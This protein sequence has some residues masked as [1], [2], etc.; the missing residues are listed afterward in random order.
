MHPLLHKSTHQS[1]SFCFCNLN[2]KS[3]AKEWT[4]EEEAELAGLYEQY[5]DVDGG[6]KLTF[7]S[8]TYKVATNVESPQTLSHYFPKWWM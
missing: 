8:S 2:R 4:E 3:K 1:K 7:T 6:G 5:R